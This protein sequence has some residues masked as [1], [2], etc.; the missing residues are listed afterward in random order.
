MNRTKDI[1][2]DEI[3]PN[4]GQGDYKVEMSKADKICIST[5]H[6]LKYNSTHHKIVNT[7]LN[8]H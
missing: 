1:K 2:G 7:N 3:Q 8:S 5:S 6:L 4:K